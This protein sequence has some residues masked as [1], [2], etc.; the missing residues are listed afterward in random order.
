MRLALCLILLCAFGALEGCSGKKMNAAEFFEDPRTAA[1]AD[2]AAK[3]DTAGVDRAA[4][5][6]A[7]ANA[8]GKTGITPLLYVLSDTRNKDGLRALVKHKANPNYVSPNGLCP[9]LVAAQAPDIDFL[10]I[11]LDGGGNPNLTNRDN[12]PAVYLAARQYRWPNLY[13]LLER[14]A[15]INSK[16][17][18]GYSLLMLTGVLRQFEQ[19]AKLI[20]MGADVTV[21]ARNGDTFASIVGEANVA[22]ASPEGAWRQ[23]VIQMLAARGVRVP[24]PRR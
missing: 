6:G 20:Q 13:L 2:S 16:D 5:Q 3:G 8:I 15:D 14:G 10:R 18:T 7:D 22:A 12:E 9:L 1:L 11:F 17:D 19:C 4:A 23:N 24:M 21:V